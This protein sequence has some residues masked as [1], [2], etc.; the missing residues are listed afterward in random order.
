MPWLILAVQ[1]VSSVLNKCNDC[2]LHSVKLWNCRDGLFLVIWN[3]AKILLC[4]SC[5]LHDEIYEDIK[6]YMSPNLCAGVILG[7]N[8]QSNHDS[9]AIY[10]GGEN[11]PSSICNLT[12]LNVSPFP[13]F[14][15]V[16]PNCKPIVIKSGR[17]SAEDSNFIAQEVES[18]LFEGIIKTSNSP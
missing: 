2:H 3:H 12:K 16:D 10:Y 17:Y 1:I 4:Y 11:Y 14:E 13:L 18:L 9:F 15:N 6:L 7:Q 8:W 5:V